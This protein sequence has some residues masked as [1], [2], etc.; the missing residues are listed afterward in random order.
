M[1]RTLSVLIKHS[2]KAQEHCTFS[3]T[4][5]TSPT[6]LTCPQIHSALKEKEDMARV[7]AQSANTKAEEIWLEEERS[8]SAPLSQR[9]VNYYS[10]IQASPKILHLIGQKHS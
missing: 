3:F 10:P 5:Q 1:S 4:F 6:N 7:T 2:G 8:S 9:E